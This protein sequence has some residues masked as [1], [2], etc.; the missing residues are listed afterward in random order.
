QKIDAELR[1]IPEVNYT[2][3]VS[4]G[5][6]YGGGGSENEANVYVSLINVRERESSQ[7]D[8]IQQVRQKIGRQGR[9]LGVEVRVSPITSLGIISGGGRGGR[10]QYI[11]SG[12]E[13]SVLE[14]AAD[15]AVVE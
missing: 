13:L 14:E 11:L 10:I 4:G 7:A 15:R 9:Q 3:L 2:L 8:I 12:P 6:V 1:K 5:S